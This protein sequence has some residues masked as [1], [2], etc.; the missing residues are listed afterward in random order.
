MPLFYAYFVYLP[1]TNIEFYITVGPHSN[2]ENT[3]KIMSYGYQSELVL[4]HIPNTET[5]RRKP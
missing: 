5:L 2:I 1:H 3:A 4:T